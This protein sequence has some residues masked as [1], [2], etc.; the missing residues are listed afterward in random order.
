MYEYYIC[1]YDTLMWE[2]EQPKKQE[3]NSQLK[4]R[5]KTYT[6]YIICFYLHTY[7]CI[8]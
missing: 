8:D 4:K 1:I 3:K 5:P 2:S 6:Q 7:R